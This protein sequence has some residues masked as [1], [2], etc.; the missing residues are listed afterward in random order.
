MRTSE[1]HSLAL[2]LNTFHVLRT[3]AAVDSDLDAGVPA[4]GL[5]DEGYRGHVFW[6]ETFV[7]PILTPRRPDLSR[8]L[9]GY[10]YRRLNAATAMARAAGF[11]RAIF[12]WQSRTDGREVTLEAV[13]NLTWRHPDGSVVINALS[14]MPA[15]LDWID[16][17]A[18]EFM[19]H[20]VFKYRGFADFLPYLD[21]LYD[22]STMLLNSCG[23]T[24]DCAICGGSRTAYC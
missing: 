23:C 22:P 17:P 1:R 9:L 6:D 21:W 15:D 7:Y 18:Y 13:E 8:A 14:F 11:E 10:R 5:H 19:L 24:Y 16:V 20:A 2:N 12:P 4:R 3:V